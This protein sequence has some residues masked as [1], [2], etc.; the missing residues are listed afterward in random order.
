M[1]LLGP[2]RPP[3][4]QAAAPAPEWDARQ[5]WPQ[6]PAGQEWQGQPPASPQWPQDP[7]A[8]QPQWGA[9]PPPQAPQGYYSP[10]P[11]Q[12]GPPPP[13]GP[14]WGPPTPPRTT[15]QQGVADLDNRLLAAIALGGAAAFSMSCCPPIGLLLALAAA[16]TAFAVPVDASRPDSAASVTRV[17]LAITMACM[18]VLG[19]VQLLVGLVPMLGELGGL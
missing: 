19:T 18:A 17:P 11:W 6:P 3:D 14:A 8:Q 10:Q 1:P 13:Y 2:A 12:Q 16:G 7:W 15:W 5:Q 4:E 9:A